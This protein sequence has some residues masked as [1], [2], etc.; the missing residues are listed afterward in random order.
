M[1]FLFRSAAFCEFPFGGESARR[2]LVFVWPLMPVNTCRPFRPD[3]GRFRKPSEMRRRAG[4]FGLQQRALRSWRVFFRSRVRFRADFARRHGIGVCGIATQDIG[5]LPRTKIVSTR[6]SSVRPVQ[7]IEPLC[8]R[9][10]IRFAIRFDRPS[11]SAA[12]SREDADVPLRHVQPH[13]RRA[14]LV[15]QVRRKPRADVFASPEVHR[16]W[17]SVPCRTPQ[18]LGLGM[19]VAQDQSIDRTGGIQTA[20]EFCKLVAKKI[21]IVCLRID[22]A[23]SRRE[24]RL[25]SPQCGQGGGPGWRRRSCWQ[26][27]LDE[28]GGPILAIPSVEPTRSLSSRTDVGG[29]AIA[30]DPVGPVPSWTI[31]IRRR[32]RDATGFSG[33]GR[34]F[35]D[36]SAT[37][38]NGWGRGTVGSGFDNRR[39]NRS[40]RCGPG[41]G[42][43]RGGESGDSTGTR[44]LVPMRKRRRKTRRNKRFGN[45]ARSGTSINAA[46]SSLSDRD[47]SVVDPIAASARHPSRQSRKNS[48]NLLRLA[49]VSHPGG[50]GARRRGGPRRRAK[51]DRD[52]RN[53]ASD[54]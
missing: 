19:F 43:V 13:V 32:R 14:N 53:P 28:T 11:I 37:A 12:R 46:N 34:R 49:S 29:Q 30:V 27:V 38:R 26:T 17:R 25:Q 52:C 44:S 5:F 35:S 31:E 2:G 1:K 15:T 42:T 4:R 23:C 33:T 48:R 50:G 54:D 39:D 20:R 51:Y 6:P 7:T 10:R 8:Q 22:F 40:L 41:R 45:P 3:Q 36:G 21:F 9:F 47:R 16:P 18:H 24:C